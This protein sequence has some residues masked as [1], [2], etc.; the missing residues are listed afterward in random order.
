M[1]RLD[2]DT[3][4]AESLNRQIIS[5]R[6]QIPRSPT[7]LS[8]STSNIVDKT[9]RFVRYYQNRVSYLLSAPLHLLTLPLRGDANYL[10]NSEKQ[11][12][13]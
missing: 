11:A 8:N 1:R 10:F 5:V 3:G 4:I 2:L 13:Y 12:L 6:T 9:L 7:M